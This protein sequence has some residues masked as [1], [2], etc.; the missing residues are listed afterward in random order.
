MF[1]IDPRT[2]DW[3]AARMELFDGLIAARGM[4]WKLR[5]ILPAV[6]PVLTPTIRV[7]RAAMGIFRKRLVARRGFTASSTA[8]ASL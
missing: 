4:D 3:D 8:P 5:D 6:V 2:G 1:P 7:T